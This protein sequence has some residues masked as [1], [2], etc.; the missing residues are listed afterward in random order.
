ML[1]RLFDNAVEQLSR[2]LAYAARRHDV[3]SQNVANLETPGYRGRDLVFDDHQRSTLAPAPGPEG[4]RLSP[5][6]PTAR[7]PRL[8]FAGDGPAKPDGNDVDLD[9]QMARLSENTLY[10]NALVQILAGQ[11]ATLKQAISGRL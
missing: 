6:G 9:H 10:H 5:V 4:E 11:F 3:L 8:V 2:G 7:R 1:A